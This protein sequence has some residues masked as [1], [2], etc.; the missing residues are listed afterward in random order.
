MK[1]IISSVIICI[2]MVVFFSVAVKAEEP[3]VGTWITIGDQG[4]DKGKQTSYIEIFEK[5]GLYFGKITK[6]LT[7]PEPNNPNSLCIKCSGD[8]KNK[9]ILG[10]VNVKNMKKTEKVDSKK[11]LEYTGG[12]ILDPDSGDTYKCTMWVKGDVLTARGYLG[13][14]LLGRSVEWF[15]LKK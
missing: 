3:I 5:D 12:T 15:R 10:M 6:L 7:T 2:F 11:G 4:A 8:L 9:P 14:S 1:K 13:I